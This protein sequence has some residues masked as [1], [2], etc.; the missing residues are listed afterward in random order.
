M[1]REAQ[2]V[3]TMKSKVALVVTSHADLGET[4]E[5]TGYWLEELAAPY[6]ALKDAG[7]E[8][9]LA[10][11]QGGL[12]PAD[13][14]SI[15]RAQG[16]AADAPETRWFND[17]GASHDI[18]NTVATSSIEADG[19]A[20]LFLVGG[21]GAMWDMPSDPSLHR[22]VS[23]MLGDGRAVGSVCH[24]PAGFLNSTS[25]DGA[26]VIAG[27]RMTCFSSEEERVTGGDKA[28]PFLIED[29]L[30]RLGATVEVASPRAEHVVRDGNLVTG[31]NPASSVATAAAFL[32]LL[33][34][35]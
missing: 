25:T 6:Y 34:E 32:A 5:M 23:T 27:R 18:A 13:P 24:G 17:D 29:E 4:G 15:E 30:R 26:P 22:M 31:Q 19:F 7:Y 1:S 20:G 11:S 12:A 8:V 35:R 9:V 10:S 16:K 2:S 3:D 28:V 14:R 33:E 21:R